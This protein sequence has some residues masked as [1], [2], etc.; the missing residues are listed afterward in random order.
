[1]RVPTRPKPGYYPGVR[2]M[3]VTVLLALSL[4][5]VA[6]AAV[7]N[8]LRAFHRARHGYD[9][10]PKS[11]AQLASTSTAT[12]RV[13]TALDTAKRAYFV[14][15]SL[16]KDGKVCTILVQSIGYTANCSPDPLFFEKTR[17]TSTVF[18]GLVGGIAANDVKK[19]VLQGASKRKT[20]QLTSDNGFLY[21]CPAPSKC[22][23]WVKT[24][25]GYNAAGKL[26][27]R[28]QIAR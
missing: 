19:V 13:A 12:R 27:S 15:V 2:V 26:I 9:A 22:A 16:Q 14:Y 7:T 24:V 23:S 28:E 11:A 17:R 21:G 1:M 25:L 8:D 6:S 3:G 10:L 4:A 18:N 20:V 5:A